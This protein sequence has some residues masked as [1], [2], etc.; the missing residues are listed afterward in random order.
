MAKLTLVLL[1]GLDGTGDLF[2]PFIAALGPGF[3]TTVI[4]YPGGEPLGYKELETLVRQR[5]PAT[6]PFAILGESFS[7]PIAISIAAVPPSNLVATV[8]CCTFTSNPQPNLSHLRWLLPFA[9]PRLAPLAAISALLIGKHSTP[10]LRIALAGA[11]SKLSTPAFRARLGAV[12]SVNV[13]AKLVAVQT[14]VLYLQALQ[15]RLV[16]LEASLKVQQANPKVQIAKLEGAHFLLQTSPAQA[17][18]AVG[19]FLGAQ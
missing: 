10:A 18:A 14:P 12:L 8:L 3:K 19:T 4:R 15:D 13:T 2:E 16:P 1:P 6:E 5:L 17:A 9:S 7:G 11:L